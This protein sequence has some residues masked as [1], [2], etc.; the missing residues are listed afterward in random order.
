MPSLLL[1][2]LDGSGEMQDR[3]ERGHRDANAGYGITAVLEGG[4]LVEKVTRP[5]TFRCWG[6][7]VSGQGCV[8]G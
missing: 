8:S 6:M 2:L 1:A 7:S 4:D 3:W 5:M